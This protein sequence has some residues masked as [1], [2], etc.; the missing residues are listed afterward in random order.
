MNSISEKAIRIA[1]DAHSGQTDKSGN[2]YIFH[3]FRVMDNVNTI[4]E[5][6]VAAL[7]DVIEDTHVT[8]DDLRNGGIPEYL[9]KEIEVLTHAP[10]MEYSCYIELIA[11]H[12]IASAVKLADLRD[13]MDITRLKEITDKDIERLRKY[14]K[15]YLFLKK[16]LNNNKN[17]N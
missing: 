3:P 1:I 14:H 7:H 8:A 17:L 2:P 16:A 6:I 11:G 12:R 9:V 4:E 15:S 5:K 13:N 10:D